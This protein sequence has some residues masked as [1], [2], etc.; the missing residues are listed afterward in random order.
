[1]ATKFPFAPGKRYLASN[2]N[3][4]G[5]LIRPPRAESVLSGRKPGKGGGVGGRIFF[6]SETA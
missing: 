4:E 5:G 2:E 3:S 6:G 1:M